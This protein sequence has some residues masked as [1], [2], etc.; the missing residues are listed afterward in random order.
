MIIFL[1][2]NTMISRILF[3]LISIEIFYFSSLTS[4]PGGQKFLLIPITYHF[5]VFFLFSF[6]LILS[7]NGKDKLKKRY[8]LITL[9][10]SISYAFLD[11]FHQSFIPGRNAG[12]Q[13]IITDSAGIIFGIFIYSITKLKKTNKP[14]SIK[15]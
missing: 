9:I 4:P 7:I 12:L 6:L 15:K 5:V 10:T 13:D 1:E 2:K 11:E 8:L 14:N 3:I